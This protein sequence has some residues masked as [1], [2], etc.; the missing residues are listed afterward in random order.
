MAGENKCTMCILNCLSCLVA[1]FERFI[2][3]LNKNAYIQI[4]LTGKNFCSA[5]KD[6]FETIWANT[7]RYSLVT[8]MGSI[9]TF[10]GKLFISFCTVLFA[11]EI[12]INDPYKTSLSSPVFPSI[13]RKN[14]NFRL[15]SSLPTWLVCYS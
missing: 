11:Y 1:C 5:A 2:E 3:F 14:I 15:Y 12:F 8:G 4:A 7:M 9:F 6:A 10:I 13:V